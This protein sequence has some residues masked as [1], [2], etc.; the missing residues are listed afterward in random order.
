MIT[1]PHV[2]LASVAGLLILLGGCKPTEEKLLDETLEIHERAYAVLEEHVD[3]ADKAIAELEKLEADTREQRATL[4]TDLKAA[5]GELD[6]DEKEAFL[7]TARKSAEQLRNR[8]ATI[9]KRFPSDRRD[10]IKS[11]IATIVRQ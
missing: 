8:F 11:L 1:R 6:A 7:V 4:K 5:M 2:L 3:D 9:V 10:R